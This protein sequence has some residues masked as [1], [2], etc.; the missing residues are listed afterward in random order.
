[1]RKHMHPRRV[2]VAEPGLSFLRLAL[3]EI[4]RRRQEF[5]VHRFHPLLVQRPRIFDGLLPDLAELIV[6]RWIVLVG[7]LAAKHTARSEPL[8]EVR[9]LRIVRIFGLL[10]GVEVIEVAEE[11]VE[12][13]HGRQVLVAIAKVVLAELAGGVSLIFQEL[14]DRWIVRAQAHLRARQADLR[15]PGSY[16]RLP[17]NEC[18]TT[19]RAALLTVEVGEHR[20]FFR[21]AIDVRRPITHDS[22]VVRTDVEPADVVAHDEQDVWL[23]RLRH[24]TL[25]TMCTA[26]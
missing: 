20:A 18:R 12:A 8:A 25:R 23:V 5:L 24:L 15:E 1:M 21:D 22:V 7:R 3:H 6:H 11:L 14:R 2:E 16:G 10:F 4:D 13:V 19:R 9:I 17:G 26:D